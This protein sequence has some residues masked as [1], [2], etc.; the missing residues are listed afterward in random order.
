MIWNSNLMKGDSVSILVIDRK[1]VDESISNRETLRE[2]KAAYE[3]INSILKYSDV[4]MDKE[5]V[6]GL[7][8]ATGIL[9]DLYECTYSTTYEN[10]DKKEQLLAGCNCPECHNQLNVSDLID[11]SYTCNNCDKNLYDF[12]V[13]SEKVWYLEE[14]RELISPLFAGE[15]KI[16]VVSEQILNKYIDCWS[17]HKELPIKDDLL[18]CNT[19]NKIIALDNSSGDCWIEEFDN[20][21][22]AK[23][24]LLGIEESNDMEI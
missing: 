6:K 3:Y 2:I 10:E 9:K 19:D 23:K 18:Y 15:S 21:I 13:D 22:D 17:E 14:T 7:E 5:T 8:N 24:W 20:E 12:E 16:K 4:R 1:T 11:Y